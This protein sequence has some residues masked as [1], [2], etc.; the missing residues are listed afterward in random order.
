MKKTLII[1]G[2][3]GRHVCAI[4]ALEKF[5]KNNSDCTIITHFWTGIFWGN[6]ILTNNIFDGSTKGLFDKIKDTKISKPEPYYNNR[7]LNN[8]I[9][10]IEAFDEEINSEVVEVSKPK[11]YLSK[12]ELSKARNQINPHK[13]NIVIQPFGS[14]AVYEHGEVV[15]ETLRSLNK[16]NTIQLIDTL[17]RSGYEVIL[18]DS[19]NMPELSN[20]RNINHLPYRDCA[21][22]IANSDYFIGVDSSGQHLAYALNK[23]GSTFFGGSNSKNFGYP[24]WFLTIEKEGTKKHS[25]FRLTDFDNWV[26]NLANDG[27]MDYTNE[28]I[29]QACEVIVNDIKQ[30]VA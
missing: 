6:P 13:K 24:D 2:G 27:V 29:Q 15:D 16:A 25:I 20:V 28:Q 3:L 1:D 7:F 22:V 12:F 5:V 4:P 21:A 10:M 17:T 18:M 26:T 19:K 9:S 11:I 30:K 23:P 14:T 8:E